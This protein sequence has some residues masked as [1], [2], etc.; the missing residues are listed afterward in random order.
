LKALVH[1]VDV[2]AADASQG[3]P[4][5]TAPLGLHPAH[6]QASTVA[7]PE[8]LEVQE[9][10]ESDLQSSHLDSRGLGA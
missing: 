7:L 4:A 9:G 8:F 6:M 1:A 10:R 3:H 5:P 2:R